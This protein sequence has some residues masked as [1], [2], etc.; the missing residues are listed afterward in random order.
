MRA[1]AKYFAAFA[2][3]IAA[4]FPIAPAVAAAIPIIRSR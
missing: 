4:G 3:L 1:C 2:V